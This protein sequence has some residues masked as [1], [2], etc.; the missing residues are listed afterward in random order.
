MYFYVLYIWLNFQ[1]FRGFTFHLT[2][3]F[4]FYSQLF[5]GFTYFAETKNSSLTLLCI[6]RRCDR[7]ESEFLVRYPVRRLYSLGTE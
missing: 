1:L 4:I 3:D 7:K 2:S 6:V 5:L